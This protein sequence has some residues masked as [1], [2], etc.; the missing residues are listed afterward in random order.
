MLI[1]DYILQYCCMLMRLSIDCKGCYKKLMR[2]IRN[3]K[4]EIIVYNFTYKYV[5]N[6]NIFHYSNVG[7]HLEWSLRV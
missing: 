1:W 3:M 7:F 4:G 6:N 5:N 2:T